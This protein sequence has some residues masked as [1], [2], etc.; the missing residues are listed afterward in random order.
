MAPRAPPARSSPSGHP[1]LWTPARR[2]RAVHPLGPS[3]C[4]CRKEGGGCCDGIRSVAPAQGRRSS[5]AFDLNPPRLRG[6]LSVRGGRERGGALL[7]APNPHAHPRQR[8]GVQPVPRAFH[9]A[10]GPVDGRH[11]RVAIQVPRQRPRL[12]R[13][14]GPGRRRRRPD[15]ACRRRRRRHGARTAAARA[16]A[17]RLRREDRL[18]Q[19]TAG[20]R[21]ADARIGDARLA[22]GGRAARQASALDVGDQVDV[23]VHAAP[24]RHGARLP[25]GARRSHA[26]GEQRAQRRGGGRQR[27]AAHHGHVAPAE[28]E[29]GQRRGRRALRAAAR[30]SEP[31]AQVPHPGG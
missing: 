5:T 16:A 13:G 11:R 24:A 4:R 6:R 23:R 26:R 30:H 22:Q 8:G 25:G 17:A 7:R 27:G 14:Q 10:Q 2:L 1:A 15:R 12:P 31:A 9:R 29:A 20:R 3:G 19:G 28:H 18:L 21:G